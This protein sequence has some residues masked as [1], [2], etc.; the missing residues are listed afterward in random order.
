MALSQKFR[1][2]VS[3]ASVIVTA[4]Y[5]DTRY[6]VLHCERMETK[7][8]PA[9][10]LTIREEVFLPRRFGAVFTDEKMSA[11]NKQAVQYYLSYK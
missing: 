9:V 1:D 5:T 2:A 8:G 3:G 11:I 6:P 10:H 7:Y 4:L